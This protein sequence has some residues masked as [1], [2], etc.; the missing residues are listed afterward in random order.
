V[1]FGVARRGGRGDGS[2]I[3]LRDREV[4]EGT[5]GGRISG[6]VAKFK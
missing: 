1:V 4:K 5:A 3:E 6:S 2:P